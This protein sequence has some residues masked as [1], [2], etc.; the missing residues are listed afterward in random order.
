M[1]NINKFSIFLI[2]LLFITYSTFS[3]DEPNNVTICWDTSLSMLERDIKKEFDVLDKIF[4]RHSNVKVQLLLF[5]IIVEEQSFEIIDGNWSELKEVLAKTVPDGATLYEGLE[6]HILNSESYFFTDGNSL[7]END[8][9]PINKGNV[10]V[11]T[12]KDPNFKLLEKSVLIG[13]GRLMDLSFDPRNFVAKRNDA[14]K[15]LDSITGTIYMDNEPK[16]KIKVQIV[17]NNKVYTTDIDGKFWL[18]AKPG[19]SLLVS[20]E[21]YGIRKILPIG[22]FNND[23]D[24]FLDP[25]VTNL[26]GVTVV[27]KK[28]ENT[29]ITG[30]GTK[31]KEAIGYAVQTIDSEDISPTATDANMAIAGKFSNFNLKSDQDITE[32]SARPNATLLGN[33]YGLVVVDGVPIEQSDSSGPKGFTTDSGTEGYTADAS[34]LN[35]ENI[36]SITVLK[37]LAA[38]NRY[39]TLGNGGVLLVT[40]KTAQGSGNTKKKVNSALVQNNVYN[41]KENIEQ[42]D[43]AILDILENTTTTEDAYKQYLKYRNFNENNDSFYLD[44]FSF[45]KDKDKNI[46]AKVISSLWEKYP[47]NETYLKITEFG[48]RYLDFNNLSVILNGKIHDLKPTALQPFFN[49]AKIKLANGEKQEALNKFVNL[50]NGG[51][52]KNLNVQPI[53]KSIERELKNLIFRDRSRLDIT[54]VKEKYFSNSKM[55]VRLLVEWSNPKSEFQIQFVNPQN[56]FFNWEH[57]SSFDTKRIQDE[58]AIG[59]NMEEFEVYDDLK[60]EWIINATYI[61][62]LDNQ[63]TEPVVLLC[64]VFNNFGYPSQKID[65]IILHLNNQNVRKKIISLKI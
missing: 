9:L 20:D 44:V 16:D 33:R 64:T 34:F 1:Y 63:I 41:A 13:K 10:V 52:Y 53:Q 21:V 62:N 4:K 2:F 27:Q 58:I 31:Q 56:R 22:Y 12:V 5:N 45:F 47:N 54:N 38:A 61:G 35:P 8:F 51:T 36:A 24:I 60:G 25:D 14:I 39:G 46:A 42:T 15:P 19:D 55:N 50:E 49:E 26:E 32:F 3:Q 29:D 7:I 43:S 28:I 23:L 37:G 18:P 6:D 65:K 59:Y 11:N 30:N 40:T 48:M 57:S 17:G